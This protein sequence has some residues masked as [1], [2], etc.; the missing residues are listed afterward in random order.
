MPGSSGSEAAAD[1]KK[2]ADVIGYPVVIKA[3]A[4][5][6]GRGMT[7]VREPSEFLHA[8]STTQREALALFGDPRVYVEKYV[9][10]ARHIEVQILSDS[11]GNVVHLGVRDCSIQRRRQ[12]L[13]EETPPPDLPEK[14]I[15]HIGALAVRAAGEAG[16]VGAGTFEFVLDEDG[17]VFFIE[18]NCRLQ[19]EHPVSEMVTGIDLVREQLLIA[20]GRRLPYRQ[21]DIVQ[22]GVALECRVNAE[23]PFRGFL[24]APGLIEEFVPPGGPFIR[25]DTH[26]TPNLRI[27]ADYDPLIA[28]VAVWAPCRDQ[29]LARMGRALDEFTVRGPGLRTNLPFLR[30]V[31]VHP[32]FRHAKHTTS[33]VEQ[34]MSTP[35]V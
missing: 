34:M 31:L 33:L 11:Y 3:V 21:A 22:S 35:L 8:F 12:K 9:D 19:V 27:T 24:P 28:K 14:A 32:L 25:V 26:A 10:A 5:G 13:I 4:G 30:D 29:V 18:A 1:A 7:V 16:Y 15:E 20:S 17:A 2:T 23:D 6:G